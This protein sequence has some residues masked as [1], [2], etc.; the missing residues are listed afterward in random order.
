M[1]T[2]RELAYRAAEKGC[3]DREWQARTPAPQ[4]SVSSLQAEWGRP[5]GLPGPFSASCHLPDVI[6]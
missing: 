4:W 2:G 6:K 1:V 3:C 5:P